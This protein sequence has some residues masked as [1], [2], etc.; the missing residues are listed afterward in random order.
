MSKQQIR[1]AGLSAVA[2]MAMCSIAPASWA[3]LSGYSQ[4]FEGLDQGN[5]AAL[6]EDGWNVGANVFD[7]TGQNFLYN[8]F[9]FPAPNGGPAFSAIDAGQGGAAQGAQQLSVYND[10]NNADHGNGSGNRIEANVFQEQ[11][12]DAGDEGTWTFSFDAG[13]GNL[14]GDTT[15]LAFIKVIDPNAGFALTDFVTIDTTNVAA[16]TSFS[17]SVDIDAGQA[18]QVLQ[19]GFLNVASNFDSSGVFYDNI[20]FAPVPVPGALLLFGSAFLGFLGLKRKA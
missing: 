9:T 4:D 16:W 18:G 6:A 20:N 17:M 2:A 10:Y 13:P 5:G 1:Q 14:D 11:I 7:S 15:A 12:I 8:Y 19:F 3:A